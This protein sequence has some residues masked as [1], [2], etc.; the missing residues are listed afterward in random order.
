[1][2]PVRS[3]TRM[4]INRIVSMQAAY[5]GCATSRPQ[6]WSELLRGPV[7]VGDAAVDGRLPDGPGDGL[8]DLAVKDVGDQLGLDGQAGQRP[9]R[10]ALHLQVDLAGAR[11]QRAAEDPRVAEHVVDARAVGGE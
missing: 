11:Q 1:M 3:R 9:C 4:M 6:T 7:G 5:P 2:P 10:R 8:V